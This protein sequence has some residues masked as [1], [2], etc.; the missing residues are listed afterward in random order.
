MTHYFAW[1]LCRKGEI[2][3]RTVRGS[4]PSGTALQ[5]IFKRCW[6]VSEEASNSLSGCHVR[7]VRLDSKNAIPEFACRHVQRLLI[8]TGNRNPCAFG[9][10]EPRRRKAYTAVAPGNEGDLSGK[11]FR[12]CAHNRLRFFV[13]VRNCPCI[14]HWHSLAGADRDNAL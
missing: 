12:I 6:P 11:C 1:R 8:A 3:Y 7:C 10:E 14:R 13:C 4:E 9:D 5:V 2:L